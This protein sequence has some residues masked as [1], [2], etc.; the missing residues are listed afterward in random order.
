MPRKQLEKNL[1]D[2]AGVDSYPAELH[3]VNTLI[4]VITYVGKTSVCVPKQKII[5]RAE[6]APAVEEVNGRTKKDLPMSAKVPP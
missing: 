3:L 6:K 5:C 1:T 4:S 2:P